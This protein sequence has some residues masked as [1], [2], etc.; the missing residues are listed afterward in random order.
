MKKNFDKVF[1]SKETKQKRKKIK[2]IIRTIIV[3]PLLPIAWCIDRVVDFIRRFGKW[4]ER[5]TKRIL[6][7]VVPYRA[8]INYETK[9]ISFCLREWEITWTCGARRFDRQYCRDYRR[10]ITKYFL[11][12]FEVEGYTKEVQHEDDGEWIWV[13]FTKAE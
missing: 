11:E 2:R 8:E 10:S 4:S 1:V 12:K 13:V 6:S 3:A 9:E 5:R 7:R